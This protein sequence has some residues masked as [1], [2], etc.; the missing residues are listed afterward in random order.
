MAVTIFPTPSTGGAAQTQKIDIITSTG[1]WTSPAGVTR[2]DVLL[3]GGGGGG[4]GAGA[5]NHMGGGGGGGAVVQ[6]TIA[7]SA[8]TA[9]TITIGGGGAAGTYNN[10]SPGGNGTNSTFGSLLTAL[11][12]GGGWSSFGVRPAQGTFGSGGGQGSNGSSSQNSGS[13]GGASNF[14]LPN[15][16]TGDTTQYSAQFSQGVFVNQ[17]T[18]GY[19][20]NNLFF[21][22]NPGLN[23]YGA[24]GGGA[25]VS[26]ITAQRIPG[27]LNAGIGAIE[28]TAATAAAAN[29]GGGGG[30]GT[31]T[32][33][34]T[35]RLAGA[36]GSGVCI[37]R[38]WS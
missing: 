11:G 36:G 20:F 5:V 9:Y 14:F 15:L 24:G 26:T 32:N 1:T 23:G 2:V 29:F 3:V 6:Q 16:N 25:S 7:I 38:Y 18:F 10:S 28:T 17:G 8:S 13:G 22:G 34:D 37:I 19:R 33:V 31:S 12:G 30:G 35:P 4:G 27:G 21:P